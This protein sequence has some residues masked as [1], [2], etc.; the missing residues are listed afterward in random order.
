VPGKMREWTRRRGARAAAGVEAAV[1]EAGK[2]RRRWRRRLAPY[3]YSQ[4]VD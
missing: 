1:A 4:A 3:A 2:T